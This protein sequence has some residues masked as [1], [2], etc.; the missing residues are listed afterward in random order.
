[1]L[2]FKTMLAMVADMFCRDGG[3]DRTCVVN[4]MLSSLEDFRRWAQN[5]DAG[6]ENLCVFLVTEADGQYTCIPGPFLETLEHVLAIEHLRVTFVSLNQAALAARLNAELQG[7]EFGQ[8]GI[9]E[10]ELAES[11]AAIADGMR[12]YA[13]RETRLKS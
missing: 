11:S 12:R 9:T 13:R 2:G 1:M 4:A 6:G 5:I 3:L 7:A 8:F 10:G